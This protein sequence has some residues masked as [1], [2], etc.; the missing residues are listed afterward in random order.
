MHMLF[1][2]ELRTLKER[3]GLGHVVRLSGIVTGVREG[4]LPREAA[5]WSTEWGRESIPA[6]GTAGAKTPR[7][8][9]AWHVLG[10][11]IRLLQLSVD[12]QGPAL[13]PAHLAFCSATRGCSTTDSGWA[14]SSLGTSPQLPTVLGTQEAQHE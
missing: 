13:H 6:E 3:D 8:S 12:G 2:T 14:P 5:G 11:K 4:Q 1:K 10:P 9:G 7:N